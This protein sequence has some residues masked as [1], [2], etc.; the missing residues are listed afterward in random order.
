MC[1]LRRRWYWWTGV[2]GAA[3]LLQAAGCQ[4]DQ[5]S[6]TQ[7]GSV[8]SDALFFLLDNALVHLTT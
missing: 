1:K 5:T 6:A 3:W 2:S 4:L 7:V 8:V